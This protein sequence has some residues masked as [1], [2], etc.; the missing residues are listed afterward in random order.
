ME[1][2]GANEIDFSQGFSQKV[3]QNV[4]TDLDPNC[5]T[6]LWY[7]TK[8]IMAFKELNMAQ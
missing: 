8:S 2:N 4:G 6:P 5:L 1:K 7:W 3:A